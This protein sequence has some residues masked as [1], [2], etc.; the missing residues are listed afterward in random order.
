MPIKAYVA[1]IGIDIDEGETR[2][3]VVV[4]NDQDQRCLAA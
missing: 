4:V 2:E 3:G 1:Y